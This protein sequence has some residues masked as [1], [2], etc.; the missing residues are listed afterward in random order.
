MK[1]L[2][3]LVAILVAM[4]MV[5]ALGAISAFAAESSTG[6]DVV[7]KI[8]V[9]KGV[10]I[11]TGASV[12][13]TATL[14]KIDGVA[15]GTNQSG[16]IEDI[17]IDLSRPIKVDT[18]SSETEDF[19]YFHTGDI[20]KTATYTNGGQYVY[21]V[22]EV[23]NLSANTLTNG[24]E[25]DENDKEI[26]LTVNVTKNLTIGSVFAKENGVKDQIDN[27]VD[28]TEVVDYATNGVAFT[29]KI[30]QVSK[31]DNYD[32]SNLKAWKIVEENNNDIADTTTGFKFHVTLTLPS[33]DSNATAK[34]VIV[35][36]DGTKGTETT[37]A[38]TSDGFDVYLAHNDK[39]YFTEVPVGTKATIT[40][41]DERVGTEDAKTYTK[42]AGSTEINEA[43]VS[44]DDALEAK[45]TNVRKTT[46][47]TGILISN[48]PY[49]VLALVAVG[50]LV[51]YV[52]VRRKADEA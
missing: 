10:Q 31:A 28:E 52:V 14:D 38:V 26:E 5:M 30:S 13:I 16:K 25:E 43:T 11:P 6:A 46:D 49:I 32:S 27:N 41:T 45:V 7:K 17:T 22:K 21:T 37:A 39:L 19:Y 44:A 48:L 36:A 34:Y 18:T 29:N 3:K 20:V 15:P 12:K 33:I 2:N 35:K 50:G 51:A 42:K 23:A 40:E 4:A 47:N 1:K 8:V 24:S 9:P